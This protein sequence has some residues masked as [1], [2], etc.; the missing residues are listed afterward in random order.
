MKKIY[1]G[2]LYRFGGCIECAGETRKQAIDAIM[3]AYSETYKRQNG[4]DPKEEYVFGT[5][6]TYFAQ[7]KADIEMHVFEIGKPVMQ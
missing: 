2:S 1:L 5:K 7:A 3:Q 6:K 4:I